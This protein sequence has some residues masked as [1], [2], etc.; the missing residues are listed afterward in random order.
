MLQQREEETARAR[1]QEK[2]RRARQ[3]EKDRKAKQEQEQARKATSSSPPASL[4]RHDNFGMFKQRKNSLTPD[5]PEEVQD[6]VTSGRL[7]SMPGFNSCL[8]T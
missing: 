3:E 6:D 4:P 2:E 7:S 1:Q 8:Y 5:S